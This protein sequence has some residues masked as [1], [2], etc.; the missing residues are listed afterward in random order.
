MKAFVITLS[1]L[2]MSVAAAERCIRSASIPVEK[3]EAVTELEAE[4]LQR[5]LGIRWNYPWT[6]SEYDMKAG[7]K[8]TAYRTANPMRRVACFLS[9]Y[10]LWKKCIELNEPIMILEHDAIFIKEFDETAFL[11]AECD[12]ISINDPRGVTRKSQEYHEK[13][14]QLAQTIQRVPTIDDLMI[15]QGLPGNSAYIIKPTGAEKMIQ[16][17]KD[18][19]AW[20]N[21]ALMCKQIIQSIA[22]SKIYYTKTQGTPSTTVL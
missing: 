1:N 20:P 18:F 3:F 17:V 9:H 22:A 16:A 2:P 12:I 14:Q 7:L 10:M 15:P 11:K 4:K 5:D 19:G 6:G 8:K 21:D 13:L